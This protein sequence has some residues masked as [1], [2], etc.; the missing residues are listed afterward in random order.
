MTGPRL[1]VVMSVFNGERYLAAA[2]ESILRQSF[3]DFELLA[4]DD[5]ST[6]GSAGILR[7]CADPRLRILTNGTNIGLTRS[8][9]RGL[10]AARGAYVARHDA[11][12]LSHPS[13][14]A[15]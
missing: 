11:D 9:N 12:D 15:R 8:L 7:G 1:S 2:L 13:R 6:D 14:F 10:A 4:I 3:S 5:G